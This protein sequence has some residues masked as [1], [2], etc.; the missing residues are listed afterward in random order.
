[1]TYLLNHLI[2]DH[3]SLSHQNSHRG[4]ILDS[5]IEVEIKEILIIR[6]KT[7]CKMYLIPNVLICKDNESDK[8]GAHPPLRLQLDSDPCVFVPNERYTFARY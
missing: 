2:A 8:Y 7:C 5:G 3:S 4:H 6:R 1:M